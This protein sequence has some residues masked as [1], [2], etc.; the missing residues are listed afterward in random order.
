MILRHMQDH[1]GI[2]AAEAMAE[3]G[4]MRLAARIA[5]LRKLGQDILAETISAENRYGNVVRFARYSIPTRPEQMELPM[6]ES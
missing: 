4:V 5:D 3:Y 2:T 1:G 6:G